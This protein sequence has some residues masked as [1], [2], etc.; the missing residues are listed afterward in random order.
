MYN[1]EELRKITKNLN[2]SNINQCENL[3]IENLFK[4]VYVFIALFC[5]FSFFYQVIL[6]KEDHLN[7]N[8]FTNNNVTFNLLGLFWSNF[9]H[10]NIIHLLMNLFFSYGIMKLFFMLSEMKSRRE[11]LFY[12]IYNILISSLLLN[13]YITNYVEKTEYHLGF[14][15]LMCSFIGSILY[16]INTRARIIIMA[17]LIG[18]SL[19]MEYALGGGIS[20]SGHI[21]GLITGISYHLIFNRKKK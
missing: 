17:Q 4:S 13:F 9:S 21:S 8:Y 11:F 7:V 19:I 5:V 14:S 16:Y 18:F 3:I 12:I 15:V 1:E 6:I 2:G 10:A 20:H